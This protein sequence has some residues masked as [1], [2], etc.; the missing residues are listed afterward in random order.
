MKT[1]ARLTYEKLRFDQSKDLHL[2]VT[3]EAPVIDWQAR[4]PAVCVI[5]VID[6]S[7]SMQGKKLHFAKESVRKLVDHLAPGDFCGLVTFTDDVRVMAPP[8]AMR[9]GE[10]AGLQAA[11]GQLEPQGS[12]NFAGGLLE[13]LR[14]AN[15]LALPPGMVR[16]VIMFTDGLANVGV[17]TRSTDLLKLL[18]ANLGQA[19]VSAFGYGEDADQELLRDIST[20]GKGNYA[21]V[22]SPE[23]AL[24]AFARELG[25][26]LSTYARDLEVVVRPAEGTELVNVISDVE[27]RQEGNAV[28]ITVP[29]ILSEEVRHLVVGLRMAARP[30]PGKAPVLLVEGSCRVVDGDSGRTRTDRFELTVEV[31]RVPAG[32]E[33]VAP[34]R[35]VDEV[36][37]LAQLVRAQIEAEERAR[38]G[39]LA[40]GREILAALLASFEARGRGAA[41]EACRR[42]LGGLEDQVTYERSS[43]FRSSM[44][45]GLS[46]SAA[47]MFEEDACMVLHQS[48]LRTTTSAQEAMADAFTKEKPGAKDGAAP[49]TGKARGTLTRK[50]SK[51]W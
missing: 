14:V 4:R 44:R 11:V 30:A 21:F 26:L 49:R 29:D 19:T 46:R 28:R 51:R 5:P 23:D 32:E 2:A 20:R 1:T 33:Q 22:K 12:T 17:A 43:A 37:A 31:E 27:S 18:D 24:T 3:L 7:G 16:R 39:E 38:R 45:K 25:G 50:K 6:V 42:I 48:G 41:A 34:T 47:G 10:K 15:E 9:P 40:A 13:G 8:A 35:E 36:V